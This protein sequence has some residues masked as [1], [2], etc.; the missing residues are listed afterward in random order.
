MLTARAMPSADSSPAAIAANTIVLP[1]NEWFAPAIRREGLDPTRFLALLRA[2]VDARWL[3]SQPE[4]RR[5]MVAAAQR[6]P[7]N[8]AA[9]VILQ[10]DRNVAWYERN[11]DELDAAIAR[12]SAVFI[13][14]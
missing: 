10:H 3:A 12:W 8:G 13:P 14:Q 5:A 9:A 11:R 4:L 7:A 2:T 1:G 6:D